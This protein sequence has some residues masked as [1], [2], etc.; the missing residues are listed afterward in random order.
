M[1]FGKLSTSNF[2]L[3]ENATVGCGCAGCQSGTNTLAYSESQNDTQYSGGGEYAP[4]PAA[5]PNV[6][7]NYLTHGYWSDAGG[8][9]RS[10]AQDNITFSLSNSFTAAQKDGL[11]MALDLWSDAA[12]IS[13]TEVANGA[14]MSM[15]V[16]NDGRAFSSSSTSGTTI[17][18]NTISIDTSVNGWINIG[19]VG[20]YAFMTALHEIGHSLGLGHTGNYNGAASYNVNAQWANDTHQTTV[21]SYF[22]DMNV[23]S[24]HIGATGGWKYSATPMLIDI[25]AIQNIYGADYTTRNGNTTYGFN[26]NAGKEQFDFSLTSVPIAIWDGGGVDTI[27]LSG[28]S[29]DQTLYLTAGDYS[30]VGHMTDNLVIAYGADIENAIGGSGNDTFYTNSLSNDVDGG[31]GTDVVEYFYNATEF[32]F[33]FISNTV[34]ALTHIVQNFTDTLSNI[35]NFI[36]ADG[37]FTFNELETAYGDLETVAIRLF[38]G[39]GDYAYNSDENGDLTLT[40]ADIGYGGSTGDQ[41]TISRQAYATS[42]TIN[43]SNAPNI[44]RLYGTDFADTITIDGTHNALIGQIYSGAGNDTVT[45]TVTGNDRIVTGDGNDTV[46]AGAGNDKIYGGNGNDIL[47]GEAGNDRIYGMDDDD[48]INGGAGNDR[49]EGGN[50]NDI[51]IGGLNHDR[52]IGGTGN[53]TLNGDDGNDKIY[54]QAGIDILNGGN[55]Q[56]YL[57]GGTEN[58]LLN[59]DAHNDLLWGQDGDDTMYGGTGHD[60]M[61]GGADNDILY[62]EDGVD[63]LE[64]GTGND[65]LRGGDDSDKLYGEDGTDILYGDAGADELRGGLGTDTL[66]GGTG[67]DLMYGQGGSDTFGF[68]SVDTVDQILDFT[69]VGGEADSLNITDILTGYNAGTDD[70]NDFV[71]LNFKNADRTDLFIDQDGT[72]GDW[73][74]TA[75]IRGSD[76]TGTTVDD[77]VLSSQ[78][79][80]DTTLL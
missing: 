12:D 72:G 40:A 15:V 65:E 18:S 6:F 77:L 68:T 59:G 11:R 22:N 30:S 9:N 31:A 47:N 17:I 56:D 62:G 21:M 8:S 60:I 54:G 19:N 13:F 49:L 71:L 44:V 76:F 7:A 39:G 53:D 45:I 70:I 25:L 20:D 74:Q 66:V 80:T 16:G 36:F 37:T 26:S 46:N 79:I 63:R 14:N 1:G 78:L 33:N 57:Y 2:T 48:T 35:E 69:L 52:L 28:Y 43:D 75:I 55:G 67:T 5:D 38:W 27:D 4:G 29:T 3:D 32:A 23:G 51:L 50:G 61:E 24:D 64:G 41:M 10:W 34:V 73:V 58:D 42:V